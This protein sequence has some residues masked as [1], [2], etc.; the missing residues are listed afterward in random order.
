VCVGARIWRR[1]SESCRRDRHRASAV[2]AGQPCACTAARRGRIAHSPTLRAANTRPH[3]SQR[4]DRAS[5]PATWRSAT[6]AGAPP[7]EQKVQY[8]FSPTRD[9]PKLGTEISVG[10]SPVGAD[11]KKSSRHEIAELEAAA[12]GPPGRGLQRGAALARAPL[13]CYCTQ[14]PVG[15]APVQRR[16]ALSISGGARCRG[17][18]LEEAARAAAAAALCSGR[19][20]RRRP[21]TGWRWN[22]RRWRGLRQQLSPPRLWRA[23]S[24]P[25]WY[26]WP[27]RTSA[28][29]SRLV[30]CLSAPSRRAA[31]HSNCRR[32]RLALNPAIA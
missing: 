17:L 10:V 31:P 4:R 1:P 27:T 19:A 7:R 26:A 13:Q 18:L 6:R 22:G 25:R 23:R 20:A 16:A 11:R 21:R 2:V 9:R 30:S 28:W 5:P 29:G 15:A 8:G 32:P 14:C 12:A 3:R 24:A